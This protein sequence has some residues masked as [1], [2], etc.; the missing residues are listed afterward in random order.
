MTFAEHRKIGVINQVDVRDYAP[1]HVVIVA[2]IS[3]CLLIA[4]LFNVEHVEF[5]ELFEA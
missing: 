5:D 2:L 4:I 1:G 3:S